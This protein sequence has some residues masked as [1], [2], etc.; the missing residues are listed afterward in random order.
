MSKAIGSY[1]STVRNVTTAQAKHEEEEL[2]DLVRG[3]WDTCEAIGR[4]F[5]F[6]PRE[7]TNEQHKAL[8]HILASRDLVMDVSG[9]AGAGKSHL[10]KQAAGA[11]VSVGKS[12][13][14]LSPTDASVKEL[15]K[16]VSRRE[17]F[18]DSNSDQ[19]AQRCL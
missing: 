10:L 9:I 5:A 17:P 1:S 13:A 11:V 6:D 2:L 4:D 14:I 12:I 3:G 19:N 16:P 15:R 7:V 8:E 18:K